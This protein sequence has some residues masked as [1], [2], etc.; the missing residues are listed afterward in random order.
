MSTTLRAESPEIGLRALK[1]SPVIVATDGREQSDPA[2]IA[3]RVFAGEAADALR[4][5]TVVRALP[6]VTPEAAIPYSVDLEATR[7]DQQKR[8][9][10]EQMHRL[11]IDDTDV[12]PEVYDGDAASRIAE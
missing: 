3:G 9:V 2:V 8:S 10:A 6:I 5:V 12:E 7:H 1:A 4:I 11:W